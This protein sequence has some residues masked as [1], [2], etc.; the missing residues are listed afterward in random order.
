MLAVRA[1]RAPRALF[2][3]LEQLGYEHRPLD[4][5]PDRLYFVLERNGFRTHHLHVCEPRST[6]WSSHLQFRNRLRIDPELARSYAELK[7]ALAAQYPND[8][9]AY[10]G[11]KDHFIARALATRID[12]TQP[13]TTQRP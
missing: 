12:E 8:R 13:R 3:V 6:F 7:Y 11:A 1:L 5:N 4:T 2:A 10:T 9:L